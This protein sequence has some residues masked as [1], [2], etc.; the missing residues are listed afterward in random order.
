MSERDDYIKKLNSQLETWNATALDVTPA[1]V[2]ELFAKQALHFQF[3]AGEITAIG[4]V[5]ALLTVLP[6]IYVNG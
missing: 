5:L 2:D 1:R 3:G 4:K 6:C